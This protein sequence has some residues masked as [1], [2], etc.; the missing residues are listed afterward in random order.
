[1][2][3]IR[4]WNVRCPAPRAELLQPG[5]FQAGR[6]VGPDITFLARG[7]HLAGARV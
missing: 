5:A 3:D 7:G 2:A 6:L 4:N 1:M